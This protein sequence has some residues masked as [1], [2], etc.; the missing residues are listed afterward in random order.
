MRYYFESYGCTMNQGE[1]R[2]MG[3]LLG[4][5]GHEIVDDIDDS[6]ALVLVTCT[7]IKTTELR[8]IRKLREFS[9]TG[10]PV[11][12]GGCMA[13]VQRDIILAENPGAILVAPH[14]IHDIGEIVKALEAEC[15]S[16][17][18]TKDMNSVQP[19]TP[20]FVLKKIEEV[21]PIASGCLGRCTYCITRLARTSLRSNP[22]DIL[23]RDIT[24][25]LEKGYREIRLSSQDNAA[26][27]KDIGESLPELIERMVQ[28]PGD[29]RVRVGMMNPENTL[30]ILDEL[31]TAYSHEKVFKFIHVPFQSGSERILESMGRQYSVDGFL[32]VV[33][34]FRSLYPD[35][36]IST[37]V[38]VGFPGEEDRDFQASLDLVE[39]LKPDKL[40]ITRFSARPGTEASSM[41]DQVHGRVAK[42]RSRVLT[43]VHRRITR[44]I[45]ERH[46]GR[47]EH[48][49][50][51]ENGTNDTM[52]GRTGS[53]KPVV[54]EDDVALGCFV[55]VRITEAGDTYLRGTV[56]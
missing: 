29:F 9:K 19:D 3:D 30:P 20:K 45:N 49:L 47:T 2:V 8:M 15:K 10:K 17:I 27:G 44:A 53:Y 13:S 4:Q 42:A 23:L 22:P 39:G 12:V 40:N 24:K 51:T 50:V 5:C 52:M 32:E 33:G 56:I 55:D 31:L 6:D 46:V 21:I 41:K 48:V 34:D 18:T 28:V 25:A 7:V 1:A 16:D 43:S 54:M 37:D 35:I 14:R 26:Y 36:T 38:I 11:V